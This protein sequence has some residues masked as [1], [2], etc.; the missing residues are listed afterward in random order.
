MN[1]PLIR[2][3]VYYALY[4][5]GGALASGLG[6]LATQLAGPGDD[7]LWKPI[8]AAMIGPIISGLAASRLPRPEGAELAAQIDALKA[9]GVKHGDMLVVVPP[10]EA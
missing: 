10:K 3:L 6:V 1:D 5:L 4:I 7:I 8:L 9:Q 2:N